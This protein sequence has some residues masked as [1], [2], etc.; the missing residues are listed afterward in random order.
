MR[1]RGGKYCPF[2]ERLDDGFYISA[3]PLK[4]KT[5]WINDLVNSKIVGMLFA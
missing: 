2:L 3:A 1:A 5:N 4:N